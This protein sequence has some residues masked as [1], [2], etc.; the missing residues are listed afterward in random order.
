MV[1]VIWVRDFNDAEI[2]HHGFDLSDLI[3]LDGGWKRPT[4]LAKRPFRRQAIKSHAS[5]FPL[6]IKL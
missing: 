2:P 3:L 4:Q 1:T 6:A 5:K